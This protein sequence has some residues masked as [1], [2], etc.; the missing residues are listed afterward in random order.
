MPQSTD[1]PENHELRTAIGPRETLADARSRRTRELSLFFVSVLI[2]LSL[3]GFS[4]FILSNDCAQEAD[5][6][7]A[8]STLTAAFGGVLGWLIK[9]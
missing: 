9:R 6:W 4:I 2:L 5:R 3:V 7:W 1:L 8:T